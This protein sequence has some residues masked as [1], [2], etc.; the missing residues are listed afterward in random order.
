MQTIADSINDTIDADTLFEFVDFKLQPF[1]VE[2]TSERTYLVRDMVDTY[3]RLQSIENKSALPIVA[4]TDEGVI[5]SDILLNNQVYYYGK[6]GNDLVV[7]NPRIAGQP[8]YDLLQNLKIGKH[9]GKITLLSNPMGLMTRD[10][11]TER[12]GSRLCYVGIPV[13][14]FG[15][16]INS[17]SANNL[18]WINV[19]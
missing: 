12:D 10:F 1:S 9:E 15:S 19:T 14:S 2:E 11:Y 13:I 8:G 3:N 18:Q 4:I 7:Y 17:I 16:A 5:F 6:N